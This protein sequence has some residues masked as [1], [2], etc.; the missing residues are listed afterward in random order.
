MKLN[1]RRLKTEIETRKQ[2]GTAILGENLVAEYSY[3]Q[4]VI[5]FATVDL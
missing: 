4:N 1:S 5:V 3:R 2:F